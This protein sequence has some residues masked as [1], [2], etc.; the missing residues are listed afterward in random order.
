[1]A[2]GIERRII[3]RRI[4]RLEFYWNSGG[5]ERRINGFEYQ[6]EQARIDE[7]VLVQESLSACKWCGEL[8]DPEKEG[9]YEF[10][11]DQCYSSDG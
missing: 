3:E 2:A 7:E 9:Y 1:M 4:S 8:Y 11:S 6:K 5:I 10:C